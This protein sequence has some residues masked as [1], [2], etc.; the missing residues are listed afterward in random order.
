M[1]LSKKIY[2]LR[3]A[4]GMS[5]EQLAEKINVS[6]QSI[7]KWESGESY[8]E[9]ERLIELSNVFDVSTDYLLKSSEADEL[10]IRTERLEKGQNDLK[11]KVQQE[12][13]KNA[14]ILNAALVYAVAMAVFFFLQ[15]PLPY[16]WPLGESF[17]TSVI[18]LA[19]ILC[20]ATAA[21]I[22]RDLKI[23]KKYMEQHNDNEIAGD[24]NE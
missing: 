3:K 15:L 2:E 16:L 21:V 7:S 5:Q 22:Q 12:H 23:T 10:T 19:I 24:E 11:S 18:V 4:S 20:L 8:P 17:Y 14:R 13:L 6:R 1:N 9:I